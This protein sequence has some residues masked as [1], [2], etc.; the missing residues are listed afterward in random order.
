MARTPLA[1]STPKVLTVPKASVKPTPGKSAT[2]VSEGDRQAMIREAAYFK[3]MQSGFN[4]D[5]M[6]HWLA[7]EKEIDRKLNRG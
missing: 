3:A 1:K 2:K 4:G 5:Y 7:A 6:A